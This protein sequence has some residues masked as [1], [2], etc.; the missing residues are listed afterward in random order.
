MIL[1]DSM[2]YLN[3]LKLLCHLFQS[4]KKANVL[5]FFLGDFFDGGKQTSKR[6]VQQMGGNH[7][8][9]WTP[10]TLEELI[11]CCLP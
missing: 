8:R 11:A 6:R 5:L 9:P 3:L 4:Y 7:Y 1:W 2:F 10:A